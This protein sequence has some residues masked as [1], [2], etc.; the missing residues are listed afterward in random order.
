M[1]PA[2]RTAVQR[3]FSRNGS[4]LLATDAASE[5][6]NL[7][8]RCRLVVHFELPWVP[9]RLEQRA[10]RVDRLGQRRRVHE[11]VLVSRHTSERYVLGPLVRR[12][13]TAMSAGAPT[14]LASLTE[15]AVASGVLGREPLDMT[16]PPGPAPFESLSLRNEAE[17]EC[18]RIA[19]LRTIASPWPSVGVV[20]SRDLVIRREGWRTN[21]ATV[22]IRTRVEGNGTLLDERLVVVV[23]K[24]TPNTRPES[25][26]RMR[27]IVDRLVGHLTPARITGCGALDEAMQ[28][29]A[30]VRQA[31][32]ELAARELALAGAERGG[33][34]SLQAGLF[35]RRAVQQADAR[36]RAA[37]SLMQ[38][39]QARVQVLTELD[40]R[41]EFEVLA[42]DFDRTGQ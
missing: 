20:P 23:V 21:V 10:G 30:S 18:R 16:P 15:S 17:V 31:F 27:S 28:I 14:S 39:T 37:T 5:G 36:E 12:I 2:E 8:Q 19:S 40:L 6:L 38:E 41:R 25:H 32:S 26:Q 42:V 34:R 24:C 7:H 1:S 29:E 9:R 13:R 35:D 3:E 33:P 22:L 11:I 4:L